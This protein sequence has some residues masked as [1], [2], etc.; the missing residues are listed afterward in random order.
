MSVILFLPVILGFVVLL[1]KLGKGFHFANFISIAIYLFVGAIISAS[2]FQTNY[3]GTVFCLS[4]YLLELAGLYLILPIGGS[5]KGK[6]LAI[7]YIMVYF[8][9]VAYFKNYQISNS[10]NI[11]SAILYS[12]MF[13]FVAMILSYTSPLV[14]GMFLSSFFAAMINHQP[15]N[16]QWLSILDIFDNIGII[17]NP[18]I[19]LL[20]F[21]ASTVSTIS[22][23]QA[24]FQQP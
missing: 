18:V 24:F 2:K 19:L 16:F 20:M 3:I 8:I 6:S 17:K 9:V 1:K 13:A 10:V 14:T 7:V 5:H 12:S 22:D 4:F 21:I 15:F 11:L 23:A